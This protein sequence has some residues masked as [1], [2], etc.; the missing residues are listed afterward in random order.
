MPIPEKHEYISE[1]DS[2]LGRFSVS[3]LR[4]YQYLSAFSMGRKRARTW[5]WN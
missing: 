5:G 4:E 3:F 2:G 1:G